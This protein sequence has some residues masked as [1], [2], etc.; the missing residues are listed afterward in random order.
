MNKGTKERQTLR[1]FKP[2]PAYKDSRVEWL[3][4]IP[5]HWEVKRLKRI[6]FVL[7]GSTP[8]SGVAEYWDG[9]IPWVTPEDLGDLQ[10]S[11]IARTRRYITEAGYLSCGTTLAPAGSLVLS[12]RAPIGHL[13]I[14]AVELCT[15]QGCRCLVFRRPLVPEFF[16]FQLIAARPE[17]ESWG[18]GSTFKELAKTKLEN[19][20][21]AV[22][23]DSEQH[24]I[25]AFLKRETAKIDALVAKKERLIELLEEKRTALIT[26][27]VTKGLDPNVPM[28]DSGVEWLGEIPVHWELAPVYARY[29]VTLG[30]ML[31][32]K[33]IT[34]EAPGRYLRNV[35]VQWDAINTDDLPEMDFA[36]WERDRYLLQPGDLLVCEGGEVGRT[37]IWGGELPECFYQ[38]AI[39]RVRRRHEQESPRF[40][41]Y[42]M[43]SFAKRGVFLAGGNPNTIDHLTAVQLRHYRFPFAPPSEQRAIA[44][45][46]DR[47]TTKIDALIAKIREG[48]DRLKEYRT[49]LICAAVTGK[50]DV[51][52]FRSLEW[53]MSDTISAE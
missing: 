17:L 38:K 35:D 40:F 13:A 41:Y 46:L 26:R 52:E 42:L 33:R 27:A 6:F 7:N 25:A 32:A 4:E 51:R 16:Y 24:T 50:I 53:K 12:T 20:A 28:R 5:A 49:A 10:S 36:P 11:E 18:Q 9:D 43:Y 1:R 21:I 31:D 15:N 47:E 19:T 30:K 48:I 45:F 34:G 3:A 29:E 8:Q 14:A 44:A 37:A 22:P 23:P 2:Y 39:H